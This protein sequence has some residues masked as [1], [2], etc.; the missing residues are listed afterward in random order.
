MEDIYRG[1]NTELNIPD[2]KDHI[3]YEDDNIIVCVKS[4][5]TA[6]QSADLR[7]KDLV[8]L[9][10]THLVR[11]ARKNKVRLTGEPYVGLI[12]RLDQPV[13]GILVIAK[14]KESA[15]NLSKQVTDNRIDKRYLAV[16]EGIPNDDKIHLKKEVSKDGTIYIED[17]IIKKSDGNAR[18][19]T[20]L[21]ADELEKLGN[22]EDKK[23]SKLEYKIISS[24]N[25]RS[26]IEV[27]LLTGRFHQIRATMA[28]LGCPIVGD[29][30]YGAPPIPPD[31]AHLSPKAIALCSH[32][33]SFKHPVT[34]QTMSFS[35][36]PSEAIFSE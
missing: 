25:N 8:S 33:L 2:K 36:E 30:R 35:I 27:H 20:G 9:I 31:S 12:H 18:I 7:S 10:K 26:L 19:V 14:D 1:K 6:T 15:A 29:T 3:I 13:E 21:P 4:A 34:G 5:G 16:V 32:K 11:Q 28:Y 17:E 24:N 22:P 23:I